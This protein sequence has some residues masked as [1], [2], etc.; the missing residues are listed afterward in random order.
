MHLVMAMDVRYC[1]CRMEC[2]AVEIKV[3]NH[4][5]DDVTACY[6]SCFVCCNLSFV[7]VLLMMLLVTCW[8][9]CHRYS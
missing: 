7:E 6:G 3:K 5:L 2:I 4:C 8:C 1:G 9:S